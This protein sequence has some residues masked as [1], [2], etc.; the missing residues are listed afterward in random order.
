LKNK[1]RPLILW[2]GFRCVRHVRLLLAAIIVMAAGIDANLLPTLGSWRH[3][4]RAP[5]ISGVEERDRLYRELAPWLPPTGQ[6]GYIPPPDWPSPDAVRDFYLASYA[7]APRRVVVGTAP[8]FVIVPAAA[9][10]APG[11]DPSAP[12]SNNPRLA[13]FGLVRTGTGG[14]RLFRRVP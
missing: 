5:S 13:G 11:T 2:D 3:L 1:A 6:I 8:E 14:T 4:D 7:L 10:V 9:S 12:T